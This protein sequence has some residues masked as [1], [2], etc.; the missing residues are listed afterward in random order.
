LTYDD[1]GLGPRNEFDLTGGPGGTSQYFGEFTW[2]GNYQTNGYSPGGYIVEHTTWQRIDQ[3]GRLS[4]A[5]PINEVGQSWQFSVVGPESLL[6]PGNDRDYTLNNWLQHNELRQN[7]VY[8]RL[9]INSE[10]WYVQDP[11]ATRGFLSVLPFMTTPSA[12]LML[13]P[14]ASNV[15]LRSLFV[16]WTNGFDNGITTSSPQ[17]RVIPSVPIAVPMPQPIIPVIDAFPWL[18]PV[19]Q[20]WQLAYTPGILA[21]FHNIF[22]WRWSGLTSFNFLGQAGFSGMTF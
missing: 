1:F 2:L 17:Q 11:S 3:P 19:I 12:L 14:P 21:T 4:F 6:G 20:P 8:G 13:P 7:N 5:T 22:G 9:Q 15:V 10:A 18:V 16:E